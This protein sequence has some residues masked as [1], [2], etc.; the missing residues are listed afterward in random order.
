MEEISESYLVHSARIADYILCSAQPYIRYNSIVDCCPS[1]NSAEGAENFRNSLKFDP[2]DR[3]CYIE[4]D[5]DMLIGLK[6]LTEDDVRIQ[7][8]VEWWRSCIAQYLERLGTAVELG[9]IA[10]FVERPIEVPRNIRLKDIINS[11]S[12]NR[13]LIAGPPD[14]LMISRKVNPDEIE[15]SKEIW[16]R[17]ILDFLYIQPRDINLTT[18]GSNVPRPP[19]LGG[20]GIKLHEVLNED[21]EERFH[22]IYKGPTD[23]IVRIKLSDAQR[24]WLHE[25]WRVKAANCLT[26]QQRSLSLTE[27]GSAVKRP[28]V[29]LGSTSLRAV[30]ME[31][32][33]CRFILS[34]YADSIRVR[35]STVTN[36]ARSNHSVPAEP[37]VAPGWNQVTKKS[38]TKSPTTLSHTSSSHTTPN[39]ARTKSKHKQTTEAELELLERWNAKPSPTS[40]AETS[41]PNRSHSGT[42]ADTSTLSAGS[43]FSETTFEAVSH[44]SSWDWKSPLEGLFPEQAPPGNAS[45]TASST[46]PAVSS[47]YQPNVTY[48]EK[49]LPST[50]KV[51]SRPHGASEESTEPL[52][53]G[54]Y[55]RARPRGPP[56][57]P[58]PL[59]SALQLSV[60]SPYAAV[61]SPTGRSQQVDK[62]SAPSRSPRTSAAAIAA[63]QL[64]PLEAW[65]PNVL[66]GFPQELVEAS[67]QHLHSEGFMTVKDL[68]VARALGQLS[69]EFLDRMGLKLGHANRIFSS[70]PVLSVE[71]GGV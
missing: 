55:V 41:P 38:V 9:R 43:G 50:S 36:V 57:P 24:E 39:K 20:K 25:R 23:T 44:G 68:S 14:R 54:G 48:K 49:L 16:R 40:I 69:P 31:D 37:E 58:T 65:L 10:S 26:E 64:T 5:G 4:E 22:L 2:Y 46:A 33:K 21:P 62:R 13:F 12:T 53:G 29:H 35:L 42:S 30:L 6:N 45:A 63:E 59:E 17:R 1:S 51:I 11:D 56:V 7:G 19:N 60:L 71:E 27:L 61:Y 18:I 67:V 34:G 47:R 15:E 32:P 66:M 3:F 70:L 8:E 28:S 52:G